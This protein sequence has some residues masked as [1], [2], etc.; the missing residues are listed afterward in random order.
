MALSKIKSGIQEHAKDNGIHETDLYLMIFPKDQALNPG[1]RICRK[2]IPITEL[3]FSELIRTPTVMGFNISRQ[4]EEWVKKFIIKSAKDREIEH[5][6]HFYFIRILHNG[7]LQAY[8][9][10][11]NKPECEIKLDYILQTA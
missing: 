11:N 5:D 4:G 2:V 8:L 6:Q 9:Y 1:F 10:V 7:N 3:T